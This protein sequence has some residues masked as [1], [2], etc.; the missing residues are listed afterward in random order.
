M[1]Y[2]IL[3]SFCSN[4]TQDAQPVSSHLLANRL[5]HRTGCFGKESS[6][7]FHS[8]IRTH[9]SGHLVFQSLYCLTCLAEILRVIVEI[10]KKYRQGVTPVVSSL[11]YCTLYFYSSCY[12]RMLSVKSKRNYYILLF[13]VWD[14]IVL[15]FNVSPAFL[16]MCCASVHFY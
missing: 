3:Y 6:F 2:G 9:F 16:G 15:S 1:S 5:G 7:F 14:S 12:S 10:V 4:L 11:L 13:L 8:E